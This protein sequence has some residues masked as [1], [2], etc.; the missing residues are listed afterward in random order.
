MAPYPGPEGVVLPPVA[1][2]AVVGGVLRLSWSPVGCTQSF[3]V[4][5]LVSDSP[6]PGTWEVVGATT[7]TSLD[8]GPVPFTPDALDLYR[9]RSVVD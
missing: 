5:R 6:Y 8:L 4:E 3:V 1:S 2:M 9:V 7:D